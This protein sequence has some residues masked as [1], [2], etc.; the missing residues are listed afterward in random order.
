MFTIAPAPA[1]NFTGTGTLTAVGSGVTPTGAANLSGT[2]TLT[3]RKAGPLDAWLQTSPLYVAH[4]GGS[5]DWPEETLYAYTQA[6][7]WNTAMALE[8]SVWKTPDNVFVASHDQT[9]GRVFAG[10]SYD[11][12]VTPWATLANLTTKTGGYPIVRLDDL[13]PAF[14]DRAFFVENKGSSG[15]AAFFDLLDAQ[16]GPSRFVSKQPA[17]NTTVNAEARKRGYKT[18]G[19]YF[20][21][22]TPTIASTQGNWDFL[23]EDY[24][25]SA[26]SW[27]A[28]QSYGKPVLAHILPSAASKATADQYSPQGFMVSG[29]ME[30]V[31]QTQI[32]AALSGSGTLSATGTATTQNPLLDVTVTATLEP[33]RWAATMDTNSYE[34]E[35][36]DFNP[37]TVTVNKTPVTT[38]VTFSVVPDGLRPAVFTAPTVLGGQIGVMVGGYQPGVYRVYAKV[39]ANPET[40]VL[41]AGYFTVT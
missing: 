33:R 2:G 18:W 10:T 32:T 1:A 26:A 24:T 14:P 3:A 34:R 35:S 38:G 15:I 25:A 40:P 13:L 11:I 16:G 17:N 5:A 41:K 28:V 12:N 21:V 30:V 22:D 31:P 39:A 8:V 37:V 27:A 23:G 6:A 29:V 20:D 9:T 7:R 19:Y 4:R 36:V